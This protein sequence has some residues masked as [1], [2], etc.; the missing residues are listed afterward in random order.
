MPMPATHAGAFVPQRFTLTVGDTECIVRAATVWP[1]PEV[2]ELES[3]F[4]PGCDATEQAPTRELMADVLEARMI[5]PP[6]TR[7]RG[8]RPV[9]SRAVFYAAAED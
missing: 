8:Q 5:A 2:L 4:E 9:S 1:I 3:Q 7:R 6:Q